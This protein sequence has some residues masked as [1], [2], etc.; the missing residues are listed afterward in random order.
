MVAAA[1]SDSYPRG[2]NVMSC[3]MEQLSQNSPAMTSS[4]SEVLMQVHYFLAREIIIDEKL[5]QACDRDA[6]RVCKGAAS[7]H[8]TDN[9]HLSNKLVFP[10]LV[11]NLY[12]D[13]ED[14]DED[15][16]SLDEEEDIDNNEDKLSDACVEQVE[17]TLHQRAMSVNLN[18]EIEASC[19]RFLHTNCLSHVRPEEELGC[20]QEHLEQLDA[21]CRETVEVYTKIEARNPY[22]HPVIGKA[23]SNVIERKCGFE[24]KSM[25]GTGV[26]E[27]LVRHKMEHPV[28]TKG[29]MNKKVVL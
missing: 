28:G 7:W 25:D 18:P 16:N 19:R 12:N 23:C 10:C 6:V 3:L 4:C 27:C 13:D 14:D 29:A 1:C 20:L 5:Y 8:M 21:G 11:R 15:D 9:E 22:L 17:R 24:A 26:M 2:H